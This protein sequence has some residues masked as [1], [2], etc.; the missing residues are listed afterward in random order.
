[1]NGISIRAAGPAD[2]EAALPL[3]AA[4]H[5]EEHTEVTA[6]ARRAAVS[7][8]LGDPSLGV[9]WL[10]EA[11]GRPVGYIAVALGFSIEFGGRDAFLDEFWLAPELRGRG[12][13]RAALRLA[14]ED[15]S[16]RRVLALHLEVDDGNEAAIGLYAAEGFERRGRYRLMSRRL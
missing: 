9:F 7:W 3:V 14:A 12:H 10:I 2:L 15:L 5:A 4:F 1:M 6:E 8:L 16:A 13:G 11:A